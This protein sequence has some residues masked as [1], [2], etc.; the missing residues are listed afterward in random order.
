MILRL[1][2][3]SE[4][5]GY[6]LVRTIRLTSRESII[7]AEGVIYPSLHSLEQRGML[8]SRKKTVEGRSRVYYRTTA[9]G[10]KRLQAL[11]NDWHRVNRG[12][13]AIMGE[14]NHV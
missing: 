13:E 5:Y 14:P 4:M 8:R 7:L 6:E 11:Q 10:R 3:Q 12:I 9:A 2:N 1:L